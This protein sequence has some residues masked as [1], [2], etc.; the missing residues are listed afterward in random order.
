MPKKKNKTI[1]VDQLVNRIR[2]QKKKNWNTKIVSK[3]N[4]SETIYNS[5]L[6]VED[7]LKYDGMEFFDCAYKIILGRDADRKGIKHYSI[8]LKS[9]S[10]TKKEILNQLRFS[11]EGQMRGINIKGLV[12]TD[13]QKEDENWLNDSCFDTQKGFF[14]L[15]DFLQYDDEKFIMRAYQGILK[16]IPDQEGFKTYLNSL[17]SKEKSKEEILQELRY[18]PEGQAR[19][20]KIIGLLKKIKKLES[21]QPERTSFIMTKEDEYHIEDLLALPDKPFITKV[22]FLTQGYYPEEK[23]LNRYLKSLKENKKTKIMI[24]KE[25]K[26]TSK[27]FLPKIKIRGLGN[28][29]LRNL[30]KK[31][32][33]IGNLGIY[34]LIIGT[35]PRLIR[36]LQNRVMNSLYLHESKWDNIHQEILQIQA[37]LNE[38]VDWQNGVNERLIS[39][40]N[41]FEFKPLIKEIKNQ[42]LLIKRM[43]TTKADG[44]E[45]EVALHRLKDLK[46]ELSVFKTKVDQWHSQ[47]K[48]TIDSINPEKMINRNMDDIYSDLADKF[49]G[50]RNEIK[51]R[52]KI[53]LHEVKRN[54]SFNEKQ[55]WIL[56]IGCGRGEWLEILKSHNIKAIGI[57]LNQTQ[58]NFCLKLGLEVFKEEAINYLK[59]CA[60]NIIGGI[61][62]IHLIEHLSFQK[63]VALLDEIKRVLKPGGL[64]MLETPNPENLMV[65]SCNFYLDPTHQNPLPAVLMKFILETKGFINTK[66]HYLNPDQPG[67]ESQSDSNRQNPKQIPLNQR[68]FDYLLLAHKP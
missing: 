23:E 37:K 39:L 22:F 50:S 67:L 1:N 48:V 36:R 2:E 68:A 57:D 65:G 60:D 58:V 28:Y 64:I 45:L 4:P 40:E 29:R 12:P 51:K 17:R 16:R 47:I 35:L 62:G 59:N 5:Q 19:K 42:L 49:R 56:D 25:L 9:G 41:L 33:I 3:Q 53:H 26:R 15:K 38:F 7:F 55:D 52:L 31:I 11:P 30:L 63:L 27:G 61:T 8:K 6:H 32:P 43:I 14:Y 10:L 46:K 18:S 44:D 20:V 21:S 24:L 13:Q 66:I 54:N 34:V